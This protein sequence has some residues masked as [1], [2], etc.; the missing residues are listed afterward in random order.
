MSLIKPGGTVALRLGAIITGLMGS[1]FFNG[2]VCDETL[3]PYQDPRDILIASIG[4]RYVLFGGDNS[5]KIFLDVHNSYDETLEARADFSGEM[6]ITLAR[7]PSVSRTFSI[8]QT[9]LRTTGKY[10][11]ATGVLR[12]DPGDTVRF[13]VSWDFVDDNGTNL[14]TGLFR[15]YEDASCTGRCI[16]EEEQFVLNGSVKIFEKVSASTSRA[17]L[18]SICH[19]STF[20]P[21]QFCPPVD[22]SIPCT[23]KRGLFDVNCPP[24]GG[25]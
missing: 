9:D 17:E 16:A 25:N 23:R 20:V 11:P 22:T 8:T 14:R 2:M 19:V 3:P 10:T 4:A 15:Y 6:K 12:M 5:L 13:E 7:D 1:V 24:T 18:I 21:P